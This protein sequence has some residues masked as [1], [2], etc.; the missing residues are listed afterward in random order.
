MRKVAEKPSK[1]KPEVKKEPRKPTDDVDSL[2]DCMS[3]LKIDDP[4]Y[5]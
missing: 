2:I 1:K 5:A 3:G 4:A